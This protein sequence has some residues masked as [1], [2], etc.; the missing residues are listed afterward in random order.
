MQ[1]FTKALPAIALLAA[2]PLATGCDKGDGDREKDLEVAAAAALGA[3][4]DK[5]TKEREAKEAEERRKAFEERKKKEEAL[6]AEYVR[7]ENQLIGQP[8]KLPKT[9]DAACTS[10][11]EIYEE[12]IKAIYYD[13]DGAQLTFFDSKSKNLGDVK[14]KCAKVGSIPAAA[15]MIHVI[16]GAGGEKLPEAD[17]KLLQGQP[18]RLFDKCVTQYAPEY[19]GPAPT[20]P[21]APEE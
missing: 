8:Q 21:T 1:G 18:D 4:K 10:L 15:C 19:Q 9:L 2:L 16:D 6:D 17:R 14:G 20:A 7:L 11:I 5:E 3:D 12:W 13:D